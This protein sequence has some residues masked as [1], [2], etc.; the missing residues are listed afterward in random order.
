MTPYRK[1]LEVPTKPP[2]HEVKG[3]VVKPQYQIQAHKNIEILKSG[4]KKKAL[5]HATNYPKMELDLDVL[6]AAAESYHISSNPK[7]YIIVSLPIVTCDIPNRNVQCF[8][9]EEVCHF[10]PLY[11]QMV[12]QTFKQK[13]VHVDHCFAKGTKVRTANNW[14]KNIEDIEPGDHVLTHTG[15]FK[16]VKQVYQNGYKSITKVVPTGTLEEI[17]VTDNHPMYVVDKLQVFGRPNETTG[18]RENRRRIDGFREETYK[19][20]WRPVSDIY[21][22]NYLCIPISYGGEIKADPNMAFLAGAFLADGCF[23]KNSKYRDGHGIL[24]TIGSHE[25]EFREKIKSCLTNLGIGYTYT[26]EA[27]KGCDWIDV[28]SVDI[29]RKL[30]SWCGEYSHGK[31]IQ[32]DMRSWDQESTKIMLGAYISG[33][34]CFDVKKKAYRIRSSSKELLRDA[35][36]AFAFVNI[37]VCVG[38]DQK[39][40]AAASRNVTD[41]NGK[42]NTITPKHDSGYVRIPAKFAVEIQEHVVGKSFEYRESDKDYVKLIIQDGMILTPVHMVQRDI[43]EMETF[44]LEVEGD[45]SYIAND[46]IVHNC[47]EDPTKAKG[48]HADASMQYIPKYDLWKINVL[49]LWDRSKDPKLIDDIL[50][51]RRNGYSMGATVTYFI[52]SICGQVDPMDQ[53]RCEHM[54]DIGSLW[55]EQNRIAMQLCTGVCYFETSNLGNE[56]ADPTAYSEDIFV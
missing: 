21:P 24:F 41:K 3:A 19:P 6:P 2:G 49:T 17:Y 11:G 20:H 38:I 40:G 18:G 33:D 30:R 7:D 22:S 45:N 44:N 31:H 53:T 4:N 32:G 15:A 8:P 13:P 55:G 28:F 34:G 5:I 1:K 47:N 46:V 54:K 36:Q 50:N 26:E 23:R 43:L 51:K 56:P 42:I 29:A 35:Q 25:T 39:V 9:I 12:Y 27:T 48:I 37:P 52:C 10:D 14:S 16:P